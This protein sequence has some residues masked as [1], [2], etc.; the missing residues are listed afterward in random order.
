VSLTAWTVL[1]TFVLQFHFGPG[2]DFGQPQNPPVHLGRDETIGQVED[3]FS[4]SGAS[5][6]TYTVTYQAPGHPDPT[7][8]GLGI[9]L[10][11][12]PTGSV[13]Q[14]QSAVVRY[15]PSNTTNGTVVALIPPNAPYYPSVWV[16]VGISWAVTLFAWLRFRSRRAR[17]LP[18]NEEDVDYR[19]D[20]WAGS[21]YSA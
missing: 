16:V 18:E 6:A 9:A 2:F 12:G 20:E 4:T 5:G 11:S 10:G 14:G 21:T 8:D 3:A 19:D 15:D 1:A 17:G 13:F 7:G